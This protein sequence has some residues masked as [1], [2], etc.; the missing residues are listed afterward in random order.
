MRRLW[1]GKNRQLLDRLESDL[2]A[3]YADLRIVEEDGT[4]FLRGTFPVGIDG[5]ILDRYQIE[6]EF[7]PDFPLRLPLVREMGG[8]IP[9]IADRHVH[10]KTGNACLAV[11]ED[12]MVRIG[13]EP[14]VL[15]FLDGPVRNF[16]IGQSLVDAGESWPSGERPH[17]YPGLLEAYG[18]WFGTQEENE[19]ARYLEYLSKG[20]IKGH[21]NCPCGSGK[22][23]RQ[24]H[25]DEIRELQQ[26]I[27]PTL[28]RQALERLRNTQRRFKA[29]Q[30][31]G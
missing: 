26:R 23:L 20:R 15:E 3:K 5:R 11:D 14:T 16:F 18:E 12:W 27:P 10:E 19:I 1:E 30:K 8:R 29:G 25:V 2:K 22:K 4:V 17:G 7:P 31:K 21:W 24:C 9:R 13:H 28:A 6:L